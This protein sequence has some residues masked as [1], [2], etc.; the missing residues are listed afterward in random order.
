MNNNSCRPFPKLGLLP[1]VCL[2]YTHTQDAR[3]RSRMNFPLSDYN[4]DEINAEPLSAIGRGSLPGFLQQPILPFAAEKPTRRSVRQP[5]WGWRAR[6]QVLFACVYMG[7][8]V[9][10]AL[11]MPTFAARPALCLSPAR[12]GTMAMSGCCQAG[13]LSNACCQA[14]GHGRTCCQ[15]CDLSNACYQACGLGNACRQDWSWQYLLPACNLSITCCQACDLGSACCQAC[16][17]G[18]TCC[19]D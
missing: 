8:V 9:S 12:P 19:Q 5:R 16:D 18:S 17:L 1:H 3:S 7:E 6:V 13:D 11:P 14:F 10:P 2:P 15:A 4:I